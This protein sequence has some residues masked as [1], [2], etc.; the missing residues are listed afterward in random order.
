[1]PGAPLSSRER[2]LLRYAQQAADTAYAPYSGLRVGAA[3]LDQAGAI[4]TGCNVENAAFPV[5]N[6]AERN[7]IAAAVLGRGPQLWIQAIAVSAMS[8]AGAARPIAPC[9]ACRQAIREFSTTARVVFATGA[10]DAVAVGIDEL[11]PQ[12]FHE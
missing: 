12:A 3:L 11:L 7:A 1:M 6:C 4:W 5:G 2:G 10:W 8:Q 9:G